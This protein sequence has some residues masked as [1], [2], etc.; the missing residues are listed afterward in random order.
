MLQRRFGKA[1]ALLRGRGFF[2][3]RKFKIAMLAGVIAVAG[4]IAFVPRDV[5]GDEGKASA[6]AAPQVPVAEVIVRTIAPSTDFTGFLAAPKSVELRSRVG[7]AVDAVSVP[8]GRAGYR[9]GAIAP[10]GGAGR[11]S[12]GR[13]RPGPP[14]GV[15]RRGLA[16]KLRRCRVGAQRQPSPGAGGQGGHRRGAA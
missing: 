14:A 7:G 16:Q 2:M 8:E 1:D 9:H 6:P 11:A 13:L 12:P 10:S 5:S 15:H 4:T 3:R